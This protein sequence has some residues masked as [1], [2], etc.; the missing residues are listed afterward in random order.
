[1][2]RS[3]PFIALAL[4]IAV[5]VGT[6][7]FWGFG[8]LRSPKDDTSGKPAVAACEPQG[9]DKPPRPADC[10]QSAPPTQRTP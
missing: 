3:L 5:A 4:L 7:V 8:L 2:S 6:A 1:M 10:P 9:Y